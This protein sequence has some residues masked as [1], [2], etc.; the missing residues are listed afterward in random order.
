[1]LDNYTD[2]T[3]LVGSGDQKI[4][5]TLGAVIRHIGDGEIDLNKNSI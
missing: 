2:D 3:L 5:G 4:V 1:M